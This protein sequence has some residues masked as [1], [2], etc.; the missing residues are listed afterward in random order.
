MDQEELNGL[1]EDTERDPKYHQDEDK[2]NYEDA[3]EANDT[4]DMKMQHPEEDMVLY[5]Y[6][7]KN[8]DV[9][10]EEEFDWELV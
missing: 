4:Q 8:G 10:N 2:D 3:E 1:Y 6:E 9:I 7:D 5:D